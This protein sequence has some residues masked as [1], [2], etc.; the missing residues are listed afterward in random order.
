M[1]RIAVIHTTESEILFLIRPLGEEVTVERPEGEELQENRLYRGLLH[2]CESDL[3]KRLRRLATT[4]AGDRQW[5]SEEALQARF[6]REMGYQLTGEQVSTVYSVI[7]SSLS[8]C[9]GGPGTGK[10]TITRAVVALAKA[11]GM[12]IGLASPTG[13]AARR[14]QEACDHDASTIHRLLGWVKGGFIH[15]PENPLPFDLLIIDEA[16]M[17]DVLLGR[18]LVA[19]ID[20]ARTHLILIG[21]KDQLPSVGPGNCLHHIIQSRVANVQ[22]LTKI[23][24]QAESSGIVV[25]AHRINHGEM[26]TLDWDD[27]TLREHEDPMTLQTYVVS[28]VKSTPGECQVLTPMHKGPI[29]NKELNRVLQQAVNPPRPDRL[30]LVVGGGEFERIYRM[31]DRVLQTKNDYERNVVNG[32]V[33][34]VVG[35]D[36]EEKIVTILFEDIEAQYNP[37]DLDNV[38][39]AYSMTIHKSQGSEYE[40]VVVVLH[41]GQHYIMLLRNLFYTA[42]TRAKKKVTVVG[43]RKAIAECVR[44][45]ETMQRYSGLLERLSA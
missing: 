19:A 45:N 22:E 40:N 12:Q 7:Q 29:G 26:P 10:T 42:L 2:F 8:V 1:R 39:L 34:V 20:P 27:C 14:L 23:M 28:I 31:G 9:T 33:G 15:G 30:E 41:S 38:M 6:E 25:D 37:K 5:L 4:P 35:V 36:V 3:A 16:S 43:N 17:L 13:R 11:E 21:D 32:D 44:N 18:A 24:R